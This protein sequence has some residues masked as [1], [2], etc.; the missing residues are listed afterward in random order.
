[1]EGKKV[2]KAIRIENADTSNHKVRVFVEQKNEAGEWVRGE[3]PRFVDLNTPTQLVQ[4][5]VHSSQRLVVEE[6]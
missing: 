4:D 2:T 3:T 1:M 6:V 5:Y